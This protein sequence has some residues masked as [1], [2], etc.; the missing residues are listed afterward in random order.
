DIRFMLIDKSK[1]LDYINLGNFD[2]K[3]N[4]IKDLIYD[5]L[6]DGKLKGFFYEYEGELLFYTEK[7]ISNMMLENSF[8]FSFKDLFYGKELSLEEINLMKEI[9]DDLVVRKR[10][11]GNFD[12][13]S[14]TF[15]SDEV[16][17]AKDYNTVL[18]E[19]E[20]T[21]KN[22]TETF[23]LE[24]EKIKK[25]LTK[26]EE[27]I[28]PQEIKL[29]QEIIDKINGKY[30]WWRNGLDAFIRRANTKLLRDQGVSEKKYKQVFSVEQKEEIKL[31]EEDPEVFDH[32][33]N[34]NSW[35]KVFNKLEVKY[36]SVIFYH[37]RT[38]NNPNDKESKDKLKSLLEEL[39]LA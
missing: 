33:N 18:F 25:I 11:R 12:E 21:V 17:F 39:F 22:Y 8:L 27:T 38:A 14:L 24:F 6:K 19:F 35:V 23:E 15:S 2:I 30:V 3:S 4:L 16:L 9:F 26:K 37:K 36:S 31:F 13:E 29:I 20:K 10:L 28:F 5:L 7:G 1:S 32:L 34:F